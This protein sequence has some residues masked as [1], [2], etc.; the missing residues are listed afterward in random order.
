MW[1]TLAFSCVIISFLLCA[2][3]GKKCVA[4]FLTMHELR[5]GWESRAVPSGPQR[6][7]HQHIFCSCLLRACRNKAIGK[8]KCIFSFRPAAALRL[9]LCGTCG[10]RY[11]TGQAAFSCE[12]PRCGGTYG[13]RGQSAS[14]LS[15]LIS[16]H[17]CFLGFPVLPGAFCCGAAF[18]F[19]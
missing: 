9:P 19:F 1:S 6:T 12:E 11:F 5:L 10:C 16:L 3:V 14:C 7:E 2:D 15:H 8:V 4:S 17:F 13:E 18:F